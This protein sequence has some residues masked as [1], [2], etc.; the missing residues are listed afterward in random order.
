MQ[1]GQTNPAPESLSGEPLPAPDAVPVMTRILFVDDEP[2]ILELLKIGMSSM[3]EEW[4]MAFARSGDEAL[5]LFK[6]KAFDVVVTDM[7]MPGMTGGQLLA[8]VRRLSP[9]TIRIVLSGY[10]EWSDAVGSLGIAHQ[11]LQKPFKLADLQES[12]KSLTEGKTRFPHHKLFELATSLKTLP[13]LSRTAS[14]IADEIRSPH[15]TVD[16]IAGIVSQ[17]PPL[18]AKLLQF[19]NSSFFGFGREV[20][21]VDEAVQLLGV[22]VIQSL[23]LAVPMYSLFS[24][25]KFNAFPVEQVWHHSSQVGTLG[26]QVFSRHRQLAEQAF[27]AGLLHD[28][29]K[30]ILAYGLPEEY[31]RVFAEAKNSGVPLYQV[32]Q[33]HFHTTHAEV[34]AYLLKLWGLPEALVEAVACHHEPHR[35]GSNQLSLAGVVHIA[36][37]LQYIQEPGS[38]VTT[39][40]VDEAYLESLNLTADFKN[41]CL[42]LGNKLD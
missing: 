14:R 12:L 10:S 35:C 30:V 18:A 24:P 31:S 38:A 16:S 1:H 6:L 20:F 32:E 5:A 11:F 40:T 22:S 4:E 26:R 15:A 41:W 39:N 36:N 19:C 17:D 13:S 9:E 33:K 37:A 25:K 23:S 3:A 42:D 28:V 34:G 8:H 21:S 29:G 27:A 2:T 7:R